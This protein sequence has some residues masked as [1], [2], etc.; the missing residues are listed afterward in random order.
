MTS[1][2]LSACMWTYAGTG[3]CVCLSVFIYF[4]VAVLMGFAIRILRESGVLMLPGEKRFAKSYANVDDDANMYTPREN[5]GTETDGLTANG[6]SRYS[7][8]DEVLDDEDS[9]DDD[10]I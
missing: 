5:S 9:A 1:L 10:L 7:Q 6:I 2:S 3:A 8:F 4:T